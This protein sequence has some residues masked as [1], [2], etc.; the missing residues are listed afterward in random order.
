VAHTEGCHDFQAEKQVFGWDHAEIGGLLAAK[1]NFPDEL[2]R[3]IAEHHEPKDYA[4]PTPL[5]DVVYLSSAIMHRLGALSRYQA[6]LAAFEEA[7]ASQEPAERPSP[8]EE[9][10]QPELP[11]CIA[12]PHGLS[13]DELIDQMPGLAEELAHTQNFV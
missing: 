7:H 10:A 4:E 2:C 6:S 9:P 8:P 12:S 11:A 5:R 3:A 1:W 13:I